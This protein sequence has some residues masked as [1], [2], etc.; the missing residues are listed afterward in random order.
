[1]LLNGILNTLRVMSWQ[2]GMDE[3]AP[4]PDLVLLPGQAPVSD[5]RVADAMSID[6]MEARLKPY[7]PQ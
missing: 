1:M 6:E 2:L 3:N 4:Y 5:G 7:G